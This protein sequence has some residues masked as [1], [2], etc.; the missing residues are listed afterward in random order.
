MTVINA[1]TTLMGGFVATPVTHHL[2][3]A[4]CA[5]RSRSRGRGASAWCPL[6]GIIRVDGIIRG[7]GE[8][9]LIKSL[10]TAKVSLTSPI[11]LVN[12]SV[13][14]RLISYPPNPRAL[15]ASRRTIEYRIIGP[16]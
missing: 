5:R 10:G 7:E 16:S 3:N 8:A 2:A 6:D 12:P 9:I 4:G 15:Y 14:T 13:T 1:Q 11:T